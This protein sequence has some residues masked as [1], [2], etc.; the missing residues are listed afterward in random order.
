MTHKTTP[1]SILNL[2]RT[3]VHVASEYSRI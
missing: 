2:R 3:S 1:L